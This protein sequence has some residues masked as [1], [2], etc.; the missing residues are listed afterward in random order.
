MATKEKKFLLLIAGVSLLIGGFV[1]Y[2]HSHTISPNKDCLEASEA[3][4]GAYREDKLT[5]VETF[6][7]YK[8]PVYTG[9][10]AMLNMDTSPKEARMFVTSINNQLSAT[11]INFASRYSLVSVG[12]TG[13]GQ[14]YFLVDRITGKTIPVAFKITY[15][16]SRKDSSLLIINPKDMVFKNIDDICHTTGGDD[17]YVDLRPYYYLWN[18]IDF[19]PLGDKA[20]INPFWQSY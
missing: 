7:K 11:G 1:V 20:P 6:D 4:I 13:W 8:V 2:H 16:E 5:S 14:N 12:M 3:Q 9:S 19:I 10:L 17:Y 15:L 18:G